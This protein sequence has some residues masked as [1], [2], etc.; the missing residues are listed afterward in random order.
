[1]KLDL[2]TT[3][4]PRA[5]AQGII[6]SLRSPRRMPVSEAAAKYVHTPSGRWSANLTPYMLQPMDCSN[7]RRYT[8]VVIAGPAR[9]GKTAATAEGMLAHSVMCDPGDLAMYFPTED[10][11]RD[12]S[13]RRIDRLHNHSPEIR[14]Q[15]S[16]RGHDNNIMRKRY[17]SGM[18]VD[19]MYPASSQLAQREFKRVLLSD[20]DAMPQDVSG[21]GSPFDLA[22]KRTQTYLSGGCTVA[23]SSPRFEVIQHGWTPQRQH[24]APPVAA[25]VLALY[26]RGDLRRWYWRCMECSH[27]FEAPPLPSWD[28][29]ETETIGSQAA[30]AYVACPKCGHRH[31]PTDKRRLNLQSVEPGDQWVGSGQEMLSTGEIVGQMEHTGTASFWFLGCAAAF[32]PWDSLVLG[33]LQGLAEV[34]TKG[35]EETLKTKRNID[36]GVPYIPIAISS[37]RTP[38]ELQARAEEMTRGDVPDG[39]KVVTAS[40][41]IQGSF[42]SVQVQAWGPGMETWII[43]RFD[44]AL[45]ERTIDGSPQ[46]IN[47]G[48]YAT[49]WHTLRDKPI[50]SMR[51]TNSDGV[52]IPVALTISDSGGGKGATYKAYEFY[53][54]IRAQG[55]SRRFDLLKGVGTLGAPTRAERYPHSS[56]QGKKSAARGD[57]PIQ[58]IN[59]NLAKDAVDHALDIAEPGPGCIHLPLWA[60]MSFF[61]E[62]CAEA[63]NPVGKWE[64]ISSGDANE[65]WDHFCYN[66]IAIQ[67]LGCDGWGDNWERAPP[68]DVIYNSPAPAIGGQAQAKKPV[69]KARGGGGFAPEGWSDRGF[70]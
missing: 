39:A 13:Y 31:K 18:M 2:G 45:S 55:L 60:P 14:S 46:A 16:T 23:E 47:P 40:I 64:K 44:V 56:N 33:E 66:M 9:S 27:P 5:I 70:Q 62:A 24:E 26:N 50:L 17:R 61:E 29:S 25:G 43:D 1:M 38:Q 32:Q 22:G 28:K 8:S 54:W 49:D 58:F 20:Y 36:Q 6:E 67:K 10:N 19:F 53:R 12:F 65:T 15:L 69:A 68:V 30:T 35:A 52:I 59:S 4:D 7:S 37:S 63:R 51:Y 11:A 3:D 57:I 21:E 34:A 42:F 48:A 41:D